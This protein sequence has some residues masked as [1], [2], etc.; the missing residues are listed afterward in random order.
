M[1]RVLLNCLKKVL[2]FTIAPNQLAFVA[3]RQILDASLMA[4]ELI[5]DWNSSQKSRIVLK[6]D[7][8]KDF[9][10]VD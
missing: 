10:M 6:L 3:N 5:D 1:A 8:E 2:P 7:L 9:D 4:N